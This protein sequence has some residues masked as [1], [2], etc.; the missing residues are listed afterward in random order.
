MEAIIRSK[1]EEQRMVERCKIILL[2]EEG[3]TLNEIEKILGVS[4]V[5]ANLWRNRFKTKRISLSECS[6]KNSSRKI[7]IMPVCLSQVKTN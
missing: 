3:K 2:T 1:T 6:F 7:F 4:R 5:M